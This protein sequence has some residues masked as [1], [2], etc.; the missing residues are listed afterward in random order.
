MT[1][2][3]KAPCTIPTTL[4]AE[5]EEPTSKSTSMYLGPLDNKHLSLISQPV[6]RLAVQV[7]ESV[8]SGL[9]ERPFIHFSAE[10]DTGSEI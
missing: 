10:R 2:V 1:R 4:A 7:R 8:Q 9:A 6:L 5:R 3:F